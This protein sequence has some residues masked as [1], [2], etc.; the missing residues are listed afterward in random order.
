MAVDLLKLVLTAT[1]TSTTTITPSQDGYYYKVTATE[2]SDTFGVAAT[3][4]Q[5]N[6]GDPAASFPTIS[7]NGYYT[8]SINGIQQLGDA[9]TLSTATLTLSFASAVTLNVNDIIDVQVV[10]YTPATTTQTTVE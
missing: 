10:D 9:S 6:T 8:V 5:D 4:F 1:S 2:N 3:S 7:S